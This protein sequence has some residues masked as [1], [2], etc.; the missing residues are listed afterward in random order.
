M[1]ADSTDVQLVA[2]NNN[3]ARTIADATEQF[4]A[5][6]LAYQTDYVAQGIGAKATTAGANNIAD[7]YATDGRQPV[8]GNQLINLKAAIDQMVTALGVTNVA[9]VG[10]PVKSVA[11]G[12][13]VN[14]SAR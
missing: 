8:T 7:G 9:G 10:T 5:K 3:R 1:A 12:I 4:Y 11:D 13:Q 2:W 6:I 14:G